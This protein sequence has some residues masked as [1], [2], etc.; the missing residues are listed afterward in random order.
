VPFAIIGISII[1]KS[2]TNLR[3]D[4]PTPGNPA[5]HRQGPL[6]QNPAHSLT[7]LSRHSPLTRINAIF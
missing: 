7:H 5:S 6:R 2:S 4:K 3:N 1:E